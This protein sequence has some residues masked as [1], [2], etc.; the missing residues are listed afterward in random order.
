M[1]GLEITYL[2]IEKCNKTVS[3]GKVRLAAAPGGHTDYLARLLAFVPL[4]GGTRG[5]RFQPVPPGQAPGRRCPGEFCTT[6]STADAAF[7]PGAPL[8]DEGAAVQRVNDL[9]WVQFSRARDLVRRSGWSFCGS[10]RVND[11]TTETLQ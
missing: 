4:L 5:V 7:S 11:I 10:C 6:P 2:L 3:Q 9:T 1:D 8:A